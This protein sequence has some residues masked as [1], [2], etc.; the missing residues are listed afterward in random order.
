[1]HRSLFLLVSTIVCLL[2]SCTPQ[3]QTIEF[4]LDSCDAC[5]MT[6][7]DEQ[8]A[9]ELVTE[10][11]RT[12]KFDA[13]EC[14]VP[15]FNEHQKETPFAL[16]LVCDYNEPGILVDGREAHYL[17]SE[18]IPSPM[19]GFLSA[20]STPQAA[21]ELADTKGGSVYNWSSLRSHLAQ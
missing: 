1:M 7:V 6:I 9:A 20:L 17:I 3:A 5:R 18:A 21:Q 10:K 12:Y 13:V 8:H 19:G 15:Y 16:I 14:M 4:G 11:G 2:I